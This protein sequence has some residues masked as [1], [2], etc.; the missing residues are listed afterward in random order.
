MLIAK[1]GSRYIVTLMCLIVDLSSNKMKFKG[2]FRDQGDAKWIVIRR[3]LRGH[4]DTPL[5]RPTP[6]QPIGR[7]GV[8][9][10]SGIF[11]VFGYYQLVKFVLNI[12][13]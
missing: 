3:L 2:K 1:K 4:N 7:P 11:G 5:G 13:P 9:H 10:P 6:D 8:G 12:V